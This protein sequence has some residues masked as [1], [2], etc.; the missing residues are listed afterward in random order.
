[1][2]LLLS[3]KINRTHLE[4]PEN[5][6]GIF[7]AV[8]TPFKAD[9]KLDV[10]T[11]EQLSARLYRANVAGLF[12]GGNMGEWY[13][14]TLQER[15]A[16]AESSVA[17]SAGRGRTILHVGC[18]RMEDSIEL[19]KFGEQIGVD[20]I[21]SLPPYTSRLAEK[22]IVYYYRQIA[23]TTQLP[24]FIYYH[25]V[26]T[27]FHLTKSA[28]ESIFSEPNITGVKY[29]DYDLL[30]LT[31]L[32]G[33]RDKRLQIFNGHDQVL[34]PALSL[35]ASGGIGSFY[36]VIPR[37][38]VSLYQRKSEGNI[39]PALKLQEQIN[40]FIQMV[41]KYPLI[42]ALKYI[43]HLTD[44]GTPVFRATIVPLNES[45]KRSL[46]HDITNSEFFNAWKIEN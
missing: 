43:L 45:E 38:F 6:K 39:V 40:E 22:D 9:S 36:N 26:L 33:F 35:G 37:A 27:G 15:K 16:L 21:A 42:P 17:S 3:T 25:P 12:V 31:N 4:Q 44:C 11:F 20:A 18:A 10:K 7:P 30:T 46:E 19:A 23:R 8:V 41:K 34:F 28:M 14:L 32:L 1:L 24:V 5:F 2:D 13:T 29:T